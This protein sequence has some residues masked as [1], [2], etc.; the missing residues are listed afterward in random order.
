MPYSLV[1]NTISTLGTRTPLRPGSQRPRKL[2]TVADIGAVLPDSAQGR[3]QQVPCRHPLLYRSL[4]SNDQNNLRWS[5]R[6][7]FWDGNVQLSIG[8]DHDV[9]V[10]VF[11]GYL[12]MHDNVRCIVSHSRSAVKE[13]EP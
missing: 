13:R 3:P 11:T 4:W 5:R 6:N 2:H 9:I 10:T 8:W 12:L 7:V 1:S